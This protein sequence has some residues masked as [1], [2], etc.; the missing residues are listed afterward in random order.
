MKPVTNKDIAMSVLKLAR[1]Q[2]RDPLVVLEEFAGRAV[3]LDRSRL[4]QIRK[5][6]GKIGGEASHEAA[7]SRRR[8]ELKKAQKLR[9][10]RLPF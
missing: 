7:Q 3:W 8:A 9:Q 4:S 1:K 6:M 10:G 5:I 2:E